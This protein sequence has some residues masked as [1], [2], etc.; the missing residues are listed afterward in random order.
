MKTIKILFL[1]SFIS[2]ALIIYQCRHLV[3]KNS[4]LQNTV[5]VFIPKGS[6]VSQTTKI[7][8]ENNVIDS[9]LLFRITA[10]ISGLEKTLKAGEYQ[11]EPHISLWQVLQKIANGEVFYRK[12]TLPEGLTTGQYLYMI[13]SNPNFSGEITNQFTLVNTQ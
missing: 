1:M 6:S 9:P 13:A 7:L 11:F 3:F 5:N 2:A 8:T 12:I 4:N 10:R